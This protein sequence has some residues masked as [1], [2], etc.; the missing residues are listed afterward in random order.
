MSD[1]NDAAQN[2]DNTGEPLTVAAAAAVLGVTERRLRRLL[3][4]PEYAARTVMLTRRTRTGT[5][6]GA[7]LPP[8]LLAEVAHHFK[9]ETNAANGDT[10]NAAETRRERGEHGA[11]GDGNAAG[12]GFEAAH[13][14]PLYQRLLAEK[15]ARI[16]DLKSEVEALRAALEREQQNH[17][18]TQALRSLP[19]P[20]VVVE[21]PAE[22]AP[23]GPHAGENSETGQ[24]PQSDA[25]SPSEGKQHE[26]RRHWWQ[27]WRRRAE[28]Q[29]AKP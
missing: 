4:Q 20:A 14:V 17:A 11:N 5:R 10:E 1:Q 19:A 15:D 16:G 3:E 7:A 23:G 13:L 12:T 24:V 26:Q 28:E 25:K 22:T 21:T 6:T 9:H 8:A 2:G 27:V 29:E 18:R